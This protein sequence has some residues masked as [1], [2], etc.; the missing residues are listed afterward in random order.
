MQE[1]ANISS[2][3]TLGICCASSQTE[4]EN[5]VYHVG[6]KHLTGIQLWA[7]FGY[8]HPCIKHAFGHTEREL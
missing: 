3:I 4:Q 6:A 8:H 7:V 5:E 1:Q 2:S